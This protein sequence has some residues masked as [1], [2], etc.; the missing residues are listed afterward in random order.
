MDLKV[1]KA[2]MVLEVMLDHWAHKELKVLQGQPDLLAIQDLKDL[3]VT[4]VIPVTLDHLDLL[5][6]L[7]HQD[8]Q[9]Q[10][11]L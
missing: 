7:V 11:E 3:V 5:V 10:L 8:F 9:V 6:H 1:T 4:T 2:P